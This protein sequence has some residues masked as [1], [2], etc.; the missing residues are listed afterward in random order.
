LQWAPQYKRR[1][2]RGDLV[3]GLTTAAR[4][5]PQSIAFATIAGLPVE[6]G[7]YAVLALM[8][9]YAIL[10]TSRVLMVGST[11]T[12]SVLTATTLLAT[13]GRN[14]P[15]LYL[16]G[17]ATLA[18]LVGGF[19][20]LS[21]VLR[22]GALANLI[23]K[24]VLTGF[25]AGVGVVILV[26]QIAK[27]L[28]VSIERAPFLQ[29]VAA[30]IRSLDTI[31]WLTFGLALVTLAI[32]I[33]LPRV[34][35]KIPA[36][37]V[38]IVLGILASAL[39]NLESQG[40]S[41]VDYIPSGLP[42]P[43]FP[44]LSLVGQLW[45]GALGIAL[46]SFVESIAAGRSYARREEPR[47]NA[48][49]ELIALG[50]ANVAS[51]LFQ[52][53]PGGGGT[54]ITAVNRQAGAKTQLSGITIAIVVVLTLLL[55]APLISLMPQATLGALVVVAA[56]R[57]ISVKEFQ[58]IRR[59]RR[60]QFVWVILAFLGVVIL[61]SLEGILVAVLISMLTI[62]YQAIH[63]PLYALGRKVGIDV[64]RPILAEHPSDEITPGLLLLAAEGRMNSASAPNIADGIRQL[65]AEFEPTVI[66]FDLSAVPDLEYTALTMLTEFEE[67]LAEQGITLWL[68]HL[69]PEP[70]KVI[71]RSPLGRKLG[72]ERMFFTLQ[73]AV[74]AYRE[75]QMALKARSKAKNNKEGEMDDYQPGG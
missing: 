2:L 11:S 1:W 47:I 66:V 8:P 74:E 31:H 75:L 58:A 6:I 14:D 21:G 17:A 24:P 64:F 63:P 44:D 16:A 59:I 10:G 52:A 38:A 28:G 32:L 60:R 36:A 12:I 30:L 51:G 15:A 43:R 22:L 62:F 41:L 33:G 65:V 39:L 9:V 7:L 48:N 68:V 71:Q 61:G 5:I 54:S 3:A 26:G 72:Q 55:L 27:M 25:K 13:V 45:P 49:Q 73:Q 19:L 37:L 67:I 40:V 56:A 20:V 35:P 57:L 4:V 53:Y 42:T 23:S 29:T 69:L 50:L 34:T 46:M 18:L 70:L